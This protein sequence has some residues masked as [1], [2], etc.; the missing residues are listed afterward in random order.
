M[1]VIRF[2]KSRFV[3]DSA[4]RLDLKYKTGHWNNLRTINEFAH[5]SIIAGYFQFLKKGGSI[6]DIGC[7]EGLLADRIGAF[8]YSIYSGFDFS[9]DAIDMAQSRMNGNTFFTVSDMN[10]H[11][12][13]QTFD[14]IVFNEVIYYNSNTLATL[15]RYS[16]FL[17]PQGIFIIS[18][19]T[20]QNDK[21]NW[22]EIE[23]YFALYDRTTVTNSIGSGWVIRVLLN[24]PPTNSPAT[25]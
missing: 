19:F 20:S 17:S 2:L 7:G 24:E 1:S 3:K 22:N 18:C 11:E 13:A 14:A 6:L 23:P 25:G 9:R 15:K 10:S 8:N 16:K 5:Y 12:P 4:E 21:I